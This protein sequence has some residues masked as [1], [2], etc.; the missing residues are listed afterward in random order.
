MH[1]YKGSFSAPVD[2]GAS[3][4]TGTRA[5]TEEGLAPDPVS[6]ICKQLD[7]RLHE[8]QGE[9][10]IYDAAGRKV[11]KDLDDTVDKWV[12]SL[13]QYLVIST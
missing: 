5:D 3:L 6:F 2:L 10:P 11:A 1:S 13:R 7:I 4:I 9:L 8:L 12:Q